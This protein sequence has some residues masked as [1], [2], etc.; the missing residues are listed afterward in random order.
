MFYT[1]ISTILEGVYI[2]QR[3]LRKK[4]LMDFRPLHTEKNLQ[5]PSCYSLS[6]VPQLSSG[7]CNKA[8]ELWIFFYILRVLQEVLDRFSG[9]EGVHGAGPEAAAISSALPM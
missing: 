8:P 5:K 3:Y 4:S 1:I 7:H 9:S 2:K 6:I